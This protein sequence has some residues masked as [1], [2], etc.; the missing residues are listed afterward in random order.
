M[1]DRG[2]RAAKELPAAETLA[3][4]L[5]A[6]TRRLCGTVSA[7]LDGYFTVETVNADS[8][9]LSPF[10]ERQK[11]TVPVPS[12]AARLCEEGWWLSGR[13]GRTPHGRRLVEA[14]QVYT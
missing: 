9:V 10:G 11:V 6:Y 1:A 13:V 5:H 7:E 2:A 12:E 4:M 3:G 8:L 14:W